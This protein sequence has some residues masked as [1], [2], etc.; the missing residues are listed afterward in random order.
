MKKIF[1]SGATGTFGV[2]FLKKIL[3]NKN[4][5]KIVVFSRDE[6]KQSVLQNLF[7]KDQYRLRFLIGD[8]RDYNRVL[9]GITDCD[10]VIHAAALKQVP[11]CETNPSESIKTNI[12]GSENIVKA[13]LYKNVDKCILIS[14]DKA[15][16]PINLYGACKLAAEKLFLASNHVRGK[17]KT[18]FS[19]IRYGNVTNSRGSV[20][21][22]FLNMKKD[23]KE[24][25]PLTDINMTRFWITIEEAIEFVLFAIKK[26][27][28][29]EI[30]VPKLNSFKIID[31]IKALNARYKIIGVRPGEK[32]HETLIS[33][34]EQLYTKEFKNY[35]IIKPFTIFKNKS[36]TKKYDSFNTQNKLNVKTIK[37]FLSKYE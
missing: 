17:N 33:K 21:P 20:I 4:I 37:N 28:G 13:A 34:E 35:F 5:K 3:K 16:N 25:L 8:V 1:I 7:R 12:L 26:M 27:K 2:A 29:N 30:F 19:V 11:A 22:F 23:R 36:F 15:V 31:L 32:I 14:T 10:V 6:L 9:E 18:K 24:I